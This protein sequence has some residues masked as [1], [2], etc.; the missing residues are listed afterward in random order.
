[1][2]FLNLSMR[3]LLKNSKGFTLI[4]TLVYIFI[5]SIL[6]V[7]ITSLG[8]NLLTNKQNVVAQSEITENINFVFA[9]II[10]AVRDAQA[11]ILPQT[12]GSELSLTMQ[13]PAINPTRF[14]LMD[15]RLYLSQGT[16]GGSALTTDDVE[17]SNL[18]FTKMINGTDVVSIKIA[19]T[20]ISAS[21]SNIH[22][23]FETSVSLRQ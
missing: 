9:K 13:N 21:R 1:M 17:V 16:G 5:S 19:I 2:L 23:S 6:L 4:E 10:A 18:S 3:A 22:S 11:V 20:L 7:V 12:T 8:F 14:Y 15:N